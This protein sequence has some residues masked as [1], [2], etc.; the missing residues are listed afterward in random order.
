MKAS[1]LALRSCWEV[2]LPRRITLRTRIENQISIL[3][4]PRGVPGREV[5]GDPMALVAQERLAGLSRLQ[6]AGLAFSAQILAEAAVPRHEFDH[7][8]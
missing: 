2:K 8:L 6:D 4:H 7:A 5:K 1:I 3:V